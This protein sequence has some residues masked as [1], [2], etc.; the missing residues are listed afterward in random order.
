MKTLIHND[1]GFGVA[2]KKPHDKELFSVT[3]GLTH[4]VKARR[5]GFTL[6]ELLVVIAIIAILAAMLLPALARAKDAAKQTQC[7]SNLKQLQLCWQMYC[8]DNNEFLP[9][10]SSGTYTNSWI[11]G[12]A[13]TDTTPKNIGEGCLWPYNKSA[14]IYACP[15]NL[16]QIPITTVADALYWGAPVGTPKPQTRTCSIDFACGGFTGDVLVEGSLY[17]NGS[18]SF[19]FLGKTSSIINPGSSRKIVF[20]D[21][22]EYSVDDGCFAIY[23]TGSGI[24]EWWNLPG[25]RHDH[26]GIFSFADGHVEYWKWHGTVV[27]NPAGSA[28]TP[29]IP[30]DSSDDLPRVQAGTVLNGS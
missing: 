23:P 2:D 11:D 14:A 29:Y 24:N 9:P 26:G 19:H 20:V 5:R 4:G 16:R 28:Y 12:S 15:S 3:I 6:I 25:S 17:Q 13:Q 1:A 22:N 18:V 21:E 27:L 30:A 8:G 7:L 10:N